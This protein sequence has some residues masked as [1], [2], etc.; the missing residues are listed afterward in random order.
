MLVF[1]EQKF[2][3]E[4]NKQTNPFCILTCLT[5]KKQIKRKEN[6]NCLTF[7]LSYFY[8]FI[9]QYYQKLKLDIPAT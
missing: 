2:V 7:Y 3:V 9:M 5:K 6:A 8:C 1:R 4:S